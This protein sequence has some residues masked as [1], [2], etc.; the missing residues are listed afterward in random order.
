[1]QSTWPNTAQSKAE[2]P[3]KSQPTAR[4]HVV[5]VSE[6]SEPSHELMEQEFE[7]MLGEMQ[8]KRK[9]QQSKAEAIGPTL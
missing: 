6:T 5:Q 7:S 4:T 8:L 1:M 9:T 2:A 3:G